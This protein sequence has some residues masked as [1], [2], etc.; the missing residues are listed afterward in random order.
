MKHSNRARATVW[1]SFRRGPLVEAVIA[2]ERRNDALGDDPPLCLREL[3]NAID[4]VPGA[5][6]DAPLRERG[7]EPQS[8]EQT[9]GVI[10]VRAVGQP[11]AHELA[12]D[13][14]LR[15]FD[16]WLLEQSRQHGREPGAS[17]EARGGASG[18]A[19]QAK[20]ALD[21]HFGVSISMRLDTPSRPRGPCA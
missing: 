5:V 4:A 10:Q 3:T 18:E 11:H 16:A 15:R 19:A 17:A 14:G 12:A 8:L 20:N 6:A 1:I 2:S 7:G 21:A 9:Q 13:I